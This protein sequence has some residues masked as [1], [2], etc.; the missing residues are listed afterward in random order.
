[1]LV[2][3]KNLL[4]IIYTADSGIVLPTGQRIR[5]VIFTPEQ[6]VTTGS[7][8]IKFAVF[9]ALTGIRLPTGALRRRAVFVAASGVRLPTG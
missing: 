2:F 6:G 4:K 1:M 5:R 3:Y 9:T 8:L 7:L